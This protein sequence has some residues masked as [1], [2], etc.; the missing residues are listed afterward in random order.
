MML[1]AVYELDYYQSCDD[2][3]YSIEKI[4][5][6]VDRVTGI[7]LR[8]SNVT[9]THS[10]FEGNNV[11]LIGA[12]IFIEFNSNLVIIN[13]SFANNYYSARTLYDY[14]INCLYR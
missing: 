14:V 6:S 11:G 13:S 2:H 5:S 4:F 12:V 3:C 1:S 7:T 8:G 10:Q 9:I